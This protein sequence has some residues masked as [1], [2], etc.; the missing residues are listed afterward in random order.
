MG[1]QQTTSKAYSRRTPDTD[2]Q[3]F[4]ESLHATFRLSSFYALKKALEEAHT[5]KEVV[6]MLKC[7]WQVGLKLSL[8]DLIVGASATDRDEQRALWRLTG[9]NQLIQRHKKQSTLK[10]LAVSKIHGGV[11]LVLQ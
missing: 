11:V 2:L 7:R 3:T 10:P 5:F 1:L 8:V 6:E 4:L 9:P